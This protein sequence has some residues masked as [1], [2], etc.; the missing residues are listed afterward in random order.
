MSAE[1]EGE[2]ALHHLETAAP[3]AVL[4]QL[5]L[6]AAAAGPPLLA[7]C[8]AG[9]FPA[10]ASQLARSAPCS[11]GLLDCVKPLPNAACASAFHLMLRL[12]S[13]PDRHSTKPISNICHP[14]AAHRRIPRPVPTLFSQP[15]YELW[16]PGKVSAIVIPPGSAT[17]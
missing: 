14:D 1:L 5:L 8:P 17:Q 6:V 13:G 11:S 12:K 16:R 2:R 10:V 3:A 7:A 9:S 15:N 4:D